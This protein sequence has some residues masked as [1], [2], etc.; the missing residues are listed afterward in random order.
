MTNTL[1]RPLCACACVCAAAHRLQSARQIV[2]RGPQKQWWSPRCPRAA[3]SRSPG[4]GSSPQSSPCHSPHPPSWHVVPQ[5]PLRTKL[6]LV[7][8]AGSECAGK[9][10]VS[11]KVPSSLTMGVILLTPLVLISVKKKHQKFDLLRNE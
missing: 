4:L 8:L 1:S 9:N 7:D 11:Y 5:E 10:A 6:Q 3:S 2:Q